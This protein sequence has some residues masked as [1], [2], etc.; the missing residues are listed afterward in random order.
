MLFK[1]GVY[2]CY[3]NGPFLQSG[4]N[5]AHGCPSND[6]SLSYPGDR[7]IIV[8]HAEYG[9]YGSDYTQP[10]CA[11]HPFD[12]F[13]TMSAVDVDQWGIIKLLCDNRT[14][15]TY[16][17]DGFTFDSTCAPGSA[18]DYVSIYYDCL[19]GKS[20]RATNHDHV[21]ILKGYLFEY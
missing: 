2:T 3:E 6:I 19:P 21:N 5:N 4:A 12:C 17:F 11:P 1:N 16:P 14:N 7:T 15:C 9:Q 10:S 18:V 13:E 20:Y 8:T